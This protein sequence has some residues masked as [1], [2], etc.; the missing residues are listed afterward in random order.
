MLKKGVVRKTE[1]REWQ[2]PAQSPEGGAICQYDDNLS[3]LIVQSA[4]EVHRSIGPGLLPSAY[5]ACL[6]FEF[7]QR[8]LPFE[9]E[10]KIPLF[11]DGEPLSSHAEVP[12]LIDQQLPVFPTSVNALTPVHTAMALS[13]L[14]QGGWKSGLIL[15]F[16]S[17]TMTAGIKRVVL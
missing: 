6:C 8:G 12:L 1:T 10:I 11:C 9:K 17:T 2:P 15:N 16:N 7:A 13:R 14:R 3:S 5:L 4:V